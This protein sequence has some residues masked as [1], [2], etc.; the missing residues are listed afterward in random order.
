MVTECSDTRLTSEIAVYVGTMS[1]CFE[2][3]KLLKSN[4][5]RIQARMASSSDLNVCH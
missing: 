1:I 3:N 2:H 4:V 5:Y